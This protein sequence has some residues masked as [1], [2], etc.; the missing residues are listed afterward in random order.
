VEQYRAAGITTGYIGF[1]HFS[2][3]SF[4][5]LHTGLCDIFVTPT[6]DEQKLIK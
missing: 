1:A 6:P 5:G 2:P 3:F 4:N